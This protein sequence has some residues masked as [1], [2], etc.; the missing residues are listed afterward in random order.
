MKQ[1]KKKTAVAYTNKYTEAID[2]DCDD[3]L[4]FLQDIDVKAPK[5]ESTPYLY[6]LK[7]IKVNG[8]RNVRIG[9]SPPL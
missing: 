7:I 3:V 9:I 4:Y 6:E 8:F 1:K 5:V 2:V